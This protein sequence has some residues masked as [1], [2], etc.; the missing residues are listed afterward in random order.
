MNSL[1]STWT[2]NDYYFLQLLYSKEKHWIKQQAKK[3]PNT[4]NTTLCNF[5]PLQFLH[6][7]VKKV[8]IYQL[9][10]LNFRL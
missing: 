3:V 7:T 9:E 6:A 10:N 4:K 2:W 8:Y 1:D 5:S